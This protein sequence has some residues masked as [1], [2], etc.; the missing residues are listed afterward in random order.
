MT[1][2][3]NAPG[4]LEQDAGAKDYLVGE[5]PDIVPHGTA[6]R[7]AGRVDV[8]RGHQR[9][10]RQVHVDLCPGCGMPHLHRAPWRR[11]AA[12]RRTAPCG[13]VYVVVVGPEEAA[14]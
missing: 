9:W 14:A 11:L 13:T 1:T 8:Y 10:H 2:N 12:L 6:P 3:E 7:V 5:S 4:L